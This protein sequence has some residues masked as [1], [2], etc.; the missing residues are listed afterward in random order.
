M[1]ARLL[2]FLCMDALELRRIAG[3]SELMP[4]LIVMDGTVMWI[5]AAALTTWMSLVWTATWELLWFMDKPTTTKNNNNRIISYY[6]CFI[7]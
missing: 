7:L 4:L 5:S 2:V 3:P 6:L 1:M